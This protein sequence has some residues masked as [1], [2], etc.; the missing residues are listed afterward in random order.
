MWTLSS[1]FHPLTHMILDAPTIDSS[2][3]LTTAFWCPCGLWHPYNPRVPFDAPINPW[4]HLTPQKPLGGIWR[5]NNPW[6]A[7]DAQIS[8]SGIWCLNYL[9][10]AFDA[11][12]NFSEFRKNMQESERS[13]F[14]T[15]WKH[16][17]CPNFLFLELEF[18]NFGYLLIFWSSLTVQSFTIIGQHWY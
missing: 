13:I 6:V 7:F 15:F 14:Q 8:S 3:I 9:G 5:P 17:C 18:S 11:P 1:D 12:N 4:C 10:V 16:D 2:W